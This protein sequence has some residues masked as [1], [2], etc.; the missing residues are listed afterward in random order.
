MNG[1]DPQSPVVR[2]ATHAALGLRIAHGWQE[3]GIT[4][5]Y[6]SIGTYVS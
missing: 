3:F 4:R 2:H 1:K 6:W 5:A